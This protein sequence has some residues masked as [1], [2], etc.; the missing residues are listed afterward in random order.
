MKSSAPIYRLK[1]RARQMARGENLPLH[2]ALDRV[3]IRE[4]FRN[5]SHLAARHGDLPPAGALYAELAPGDLVISAA[6]PGQGKTLL[7]LALAIEAMK[8]GHRAAFFSLDYTETDLVGR[9]R[10][11]DADPA[12]FGDR[13]SFDGSEHISGGYIAEKLQQAASGTLAV[14][15]YL[16]LLD[17]RRDNPDLMTQV[18]ALREFAMARRITVICISQ[19][20]RRYD[21][22]RQPFPTFADIRLPNPL[23]LTLFDKACFLNDG[24][25]RLE[26]VAAGL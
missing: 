18:R 16:Q 25:V 8:A 22:V 13:F 19:V 12:A 5:W 23:D 21:P 3:A 26:A 4:G 7:A 15:D 17:Q 6:R 1:H 2:A 9:F 10:A 14:V 24:R 11:L 20:D